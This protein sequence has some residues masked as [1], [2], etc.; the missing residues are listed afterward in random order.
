MDG[1]DKYRD[2]VILVADGD[3]AGALSTSSALQGAGFTTAEAV[4]S[5]S[6]IRQRI[7]GGMREGGAWLLLVLVTSR[8]LGR[9][10]SRE[11]RML[12]ALAEE[13]GVGIVLLSEDQHA[14][15]AGMLAD[16]WERGITD[17]L[18]VGLDSVQF[19][20]RILLLLSNQ[21]ER[22]RLR[23]REQELESELAELRVMESRLQHLVYH[24][25]LTGLWNRRRIKEALELAVLRAANLHRPCALLLIDMDRFKLVNDLEGYDAGDKFLIEVSRLLRRHAGEADTVARIGSDEF[26]MLIENIGSEASTE[27][28]EEIRKDLELYRFRYGARYYRTCASIGVANLAAGERGICTSELMARADQACFV[29][30]QHGRNHVHCYS[31]Q[32]PELEHLRRDHSWAPKIRE[33]IEHD[34]FFFCYQPIVRVLDGRITHYECLLRMRDRNGRVYMPGE[35]IPVAERTGL[36]HH[37]DMWVVDQALDFLTAL[38]HDSTRTGASI[39]LSAHAFRNRDLFDLLAK[40]LE[41]SWVSPTRLVFELTETAAIENMDRSRELVA[42]LRALGC[43]FALDDF[44]SGFSTFNYIK[45]FPVDF[46]KLD[47]SFI[48]N[49]ANDPM[50]QELVRHMISIA[51]SLG[52]ETIA[53][54][55]E[56]RAVFETLRRL[57]IDYVQGHYLGEATEKPVT[58]VELPSVRPREKREEIALL[59]GQN[60]NAGGK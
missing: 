39:N 3:P 33:A 46:L 20:H 30:K 22:R 7:R 28:A 34:R 6:E 15:D 49:L 2:W 21:V 29:A 31:D 13:A 26:A 35:F 51:R 19:G 54:F 41:M 32:D 59:L 50:D 60:G 55:V 11:A 25:E 47:G 57:G 40:R 48:V 42:R 43:R 24:D 1:V 8:L 16:A 9:L 36:I 52:K 37:V 12:L 4:Y 18:P 17:I 44:G 10:D 23:H 58:S 27:R 53:E 38:P 5:L 56:S 14:V 45:N